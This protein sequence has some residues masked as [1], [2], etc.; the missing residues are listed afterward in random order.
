V[1]GKAIETIELIFEGISGAVTGGL[2]GFLGVRA[3]IIAFNENK[4]LPEIPTLSSQLADGGEAQ[5]FSIPGVG[6]LSGTEL[7]FLFDLSDPFVPPEAMQAIVEVLDRYLV[8]FDILSSPSADLADVPKKRIFKD[9]GGQLTNLLKKLGQTGP[10]R[11]FE[12]DIRS[13]LYYN[14]GPERIVI[15]FLDDSNGAIGR[16]AGSFYT[17]NHYRTFL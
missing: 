17:S 2:A 5:L 7:P 3:R 13:D 11:F 1:Q 10:F 9:L 4:P 8:N 16:Y 12:F 15:A 14:R 6:D